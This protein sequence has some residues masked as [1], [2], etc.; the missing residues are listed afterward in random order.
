VEKLK[1]L[2]LDVAEVSCLKAIL[3]FTTGQATSYR[4][5][6]TGYK[7]SSHGFSMWNL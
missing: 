3:L 4:L 5:Q 2:H 7:L 6:N 1:V